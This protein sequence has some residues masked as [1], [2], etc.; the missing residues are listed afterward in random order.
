MKNYYFFKKYQKNH[1]SNWDRNDKS[2]SSFINLH[3]WPKNIYFLN[4]IC[5]LHANF[6]SSRLEPKYTKPGK[7]LYKIICVEIFKLI[8]IS[9]QK[10]K[11]HFFFE[12][13]YATHSSQPEPKY[14]KPGKFSRQFV[15]INYLILVDLSE[16]LP[17]TYI[18]L[19]RLNASNN[20]LLNPSRSSNA[21][22]LHWNWLGNPKGDNGICDSLP[23]IKT[24]LFK[25]H[26][27][28]K[29]A[30]IPI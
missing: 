6:H 27:W 13:S 7:F 15:E 18:V 22:I 5:N 12:I 8:F 21:F 10:I 29:L 30:I 1:V 23:S 3:F 24:I 19:F 17:E 16:N 25:N 20:T 11:F 28:L 4:L 2:R 26:N 14:T 9:D